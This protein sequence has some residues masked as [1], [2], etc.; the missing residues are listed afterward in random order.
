MARRTLWLNTFMPKT[1]LAEIQRIELRGRQQQDAKSGPGGLQLTLR[2]SEG[3]DLSEVI[4]ADF[5]VVYG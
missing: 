2:L 1:T 4:A 3:L 5:Y